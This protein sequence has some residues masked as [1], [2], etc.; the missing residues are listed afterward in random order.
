MPLLQDKLLF[1]HL[2]VLLSSNK[3]IL[4]HISH[5]VTHTYPIQFVSPHLCFYSANHLQSILPI[6]GW[7]CLSRISARGLARGL[8]YHLQLDF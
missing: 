6:K 3:D 5:S 4:Y 1:F 7:H 8:A 2:Y